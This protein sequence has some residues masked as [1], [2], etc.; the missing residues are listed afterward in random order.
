PGVREPRPELLGFDEG[1]HRAATGSPIR[2][3]GN[4]VQTRKQRLR[5]QRISRKLEDSNHRSR[6]VHALL[7]SLENDAFRHHKTLIRQEVIACE[8]QGM[9][10]LRCSASARWRRW[11]REQSNT[12]S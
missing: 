12:K 3:I 4:F 8:L 5:V 11:A 10:W 1:D 7:G 9:A 2:M 6:V